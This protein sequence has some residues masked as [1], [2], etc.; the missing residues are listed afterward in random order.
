MGRQRD[1]VVRYAKSRGISEDE[2]FRHMI[3]REVCNF[4]GA[5]TIQEAKLKQ[6]KEQIHASADEYIKARANGQEY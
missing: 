3:V 5:E 1:Y 2:A 6:A 4:Y